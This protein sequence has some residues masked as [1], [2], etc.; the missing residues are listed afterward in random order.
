M[1]VGL[2]RPITLWPFPEQRLS[3]LADSSNAFLVVEMNAGQMVEDVR[4]SAGGQ[5]PV[6]FYGRTGGVVPVPEEIYREIKTL[7]ERVS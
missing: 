1:R 3:A 4:L 2:L 7:Y 6:Q 5:V